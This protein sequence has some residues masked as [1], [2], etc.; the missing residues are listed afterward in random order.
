MVVRHDNSTRRIDFTKGNA[1]L[2][3]RRSRLVP[4]LEGL[5]SRRLMTGFFVATNGNDANA[6][7]AT[8][9]WATL[10]HAVNSV[11]PGNVIEVESG[12]YVGCRIGNSGTAAAPIT[13]EAAP[14]AS[15]VVDA[16]GP[17]NDHGS[18]IEVEN[19]AGTVDYWTIKGLEVTD[20]PLAG[21]DLRNANYDTVTDC[22]AYANT[23]WGIFS[24][25]TNYL[26]LTD[27]TA[28]YTVQQHG[29]YVSNSSNYAVITGN[30]VEYN[31]DCGIQINAD[32]TQG[33]TGVSVG[34]VIANN[35]VAYNGTGG[36]AAL[37]FDGL[38]NSQVTGND[39]LHNYAG[40]I[41]LY[42]YD[43]AAGSINNLVK[44]NTIVMAPGARFAIN[45]YVGSTGNQL[46][47]NA[48]LSTSGDIE[49]DASSLSGFV[50]NDNVFYGSPIFSANEGNTFLS[51]SGWIAATGQDKNST[52]I[53]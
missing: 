34:C 33:G 16:P 49:I 2:R 52:V 28:S 29:I 31:H 21:I 1:I 40:G 35:T 50:S 38:Q 22:D 5:E 19:F 53:T 45:I 4:G 41:V 36:G 7:T 39:V 18:D 6:G 47:G 37:N 13:L 8:A 14:G 20:A 24:A 42:K 48:I 17:D 23:T 51:L 46:I 26:T 12:T 32:A 3:S 30:T 27:N 11:S 9:P 44:D 25:F 10:Q 43:A 15:V